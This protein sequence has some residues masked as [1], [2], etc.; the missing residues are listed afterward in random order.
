MAKIV[1]LLRKAYEHDQN[2]R[3]LLNNEARSVSSE[4]ASADT[5]C[6]VCVAIN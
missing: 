3:S 6:F 5:I 4:N 2:I 1:L